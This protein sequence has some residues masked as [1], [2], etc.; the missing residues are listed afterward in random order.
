MNRRSFIHAGAVGSLSLPS[1]LSGEVD[2]HIVA[3]AKSLIHVYLPGG[4]AHQESWDPKPYSPLEYRGPFTAIN[5]KVDGLQFGEVMK[6]MAKVADKITVIHSMTHGEA[7]HDR[8][9]QNMF[10]GYKP[11]PALKFPSFGSV[12]THELGTRE[13]LPPYICIPKLP[14][15][16]AGSGFLSPAYSPFG[17]GSDP[18]SPDF[19]VR[20]IALPDG[21]NENR[22]LK[23]RSLLDMIE[24]EFN[25]AERSKQLDAMNSFYQD[26]YSMIASRKAREAFDINREKNKTKRQPPGGTK[27]NE[28]LFPR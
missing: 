24:S 20:D 26:A 14:N 15:P 19:K 11:S 27:C 10:T 12:V 5:T 9:T 4:M 2:S 3:K 13:A 16:H 6:D 18:A 21:I 28:P 25:A 7:A 1:L 23:R 8:G 17:L 22:F